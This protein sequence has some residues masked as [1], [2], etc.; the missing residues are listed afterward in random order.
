M[1]FEEYLERYAHERCEW[2]EETVIQMSPAGKLHNA[3][4]LCLAT[5][6]QAY[7]EWKPIGEVIIQPFP[8]KLDKAKRQ[9]SL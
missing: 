1:T 6:L 2:V 5:L 4:I 3:I 8:M 7:F 9:R